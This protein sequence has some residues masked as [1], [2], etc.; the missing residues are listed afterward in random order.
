MRIVAGAPAARARSTS[1]TQ[2]SAVSVNFGRFAT[3]NWYGM[4][5]IS[6]VQENVAYAAWS[7]G[8]ASSARAQSSHTSDHSAASVILSSRALVTADR[9]PVAL[10]LCE[11]M[12][13]FFD[14]SSRRF[15]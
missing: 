8:S 6:S 4:R 13:V 11:M 7:A 5:R 1:A 15:K 14:T 12:P 2:L 9:Q 3:L 10:R